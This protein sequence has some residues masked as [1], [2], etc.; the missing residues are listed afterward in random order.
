MNTF[1][2]NMN[3]IHTTQ[4]PINDNEF[5]NERQSPT[6]ISHKRASGLGV[7]KAEMIAH[8]EGKSFSKPKNPVV[9]GNSIAYP[10][11]VDP[12]FQTHVS[13]NHGLLDQFE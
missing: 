7:S 13:Q 12:Q 11:R 6:A 1:A 4:T 8:I 10:G 3:I 9:I 2:A 5:A